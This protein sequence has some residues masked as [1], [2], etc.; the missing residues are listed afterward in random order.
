MM[1]TYLKSLDD[2]KKQAAHLVAGILARKNGKEAAVVALYGDL[3]SG[4]TTF[5]KAAAESLGVSLPVV[6]PTFVILRIYPL[7]T[8]PFSHFIHVDAYRL[9]DG[10][11]LKKLGWND[12][13]SDP[14]NIIFVEWADKVEDILPKGTV[15]VYFENINETT[16]S[17]KIKEK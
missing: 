1:E 5:T 11:E 9:E 4:K 12:M 15:M 3:G 6:S 10:E 17:L 14:K 7:Q 2:V 13:L 8:E 16:R